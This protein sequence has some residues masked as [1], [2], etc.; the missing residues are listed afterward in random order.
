[1]SGFRDRLDQANSG[2]PAVGPGFP[3]ARRRLKKTSIDRARATPA[4]PKSA[5]EVHR[6]RALPCPH[7]I[8]DIV[9]A[10]T[11]VLSLRLH[12]IAT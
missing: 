9:L 1:V 5:R 7:G 3:S 2:L 12:T 6:R 4:N 11:Y 10:A 8:L